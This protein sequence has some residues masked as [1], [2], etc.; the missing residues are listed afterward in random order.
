MLTSEPNSLQPHAVIEHFVDAD[1]A[2]EF[3]SIERR[4]VLDWA[5]A[6]K[7]PGHP[8]GEGQRRVWRFLVSELADW[9]KKQ[10]NS[11]TP[12]ASKKVRF[13]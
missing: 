13:Q 12:G 8:L 6:G 2:A 10:D 1:R 5:R 3:L 9:A 11:F 7:L 4:M